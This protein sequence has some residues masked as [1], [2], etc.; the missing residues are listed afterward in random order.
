MLW[1]FQD[2][3]IED[4]DGVLHRPTCTELAGVTDR[5]PAGSSVRRDIAPRECWACRP[6]LEIVLGV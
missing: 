3:T 5:H 1:R 4:S 2:E 6:D